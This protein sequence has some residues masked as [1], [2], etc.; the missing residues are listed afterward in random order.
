MTGDQILREFAPPP[1]L[2]G[3][4]WGDWTLDIERLCLVHLAFP[5][6][7]GNGS[8]RTEGVPP[9]TAFWGDYEIDLERACDSAAMLDWIYQIRG[10]GWASARVMKDLLE[11]FHDILHPQGNLCSG[12][13]GGGGGGMVI[14]NPG[15]FLR[16][17]IATVGRTK[18][19]A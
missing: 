19:A 6:D 16:R 5:V 13:C 3:R 2:H 8:G 10:K 4:K 11:A 1:L 14:K 12:A 17:R 7:L 18:E 9:Y 15:A